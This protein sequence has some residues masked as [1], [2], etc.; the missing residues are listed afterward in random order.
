MARDEIW[1]AGQCFSAP[2]GCERI[3]GERVDVLIVSDV[4]EN[5]QCNVEHGANVKVRAARFWYVPL[6]AGLGFCLERSH[7]RRI[8]CLGYN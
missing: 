3:E 6:H 4:T 5:L 8:T 2:F 1:R 7:K